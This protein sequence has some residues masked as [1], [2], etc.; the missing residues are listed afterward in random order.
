[1]KK[2]LKEICSAYNITEVG[3]CPM[4]PYENLGTR[5]KNRAEFNTGF[6]EEDLDKRINPHLLMPKGQ[7]II[8]CLFPYYTGKQSGNLS[9][10]TY[11]KDYHLLCKELLNQVGEDLKK[12]IPDLEYMSFADT[13]PL[14]DRYLAHEAGLGFYG[15][16]SHLINDTFGSYFFIGYMITNYPFERDY[17]LDK[18]CFGCLACKRKCP[19]QIILGNYDIDGRGCRSFITQKKGELDPQDLKVLRRGDKI[20]GCDVCQQVCPHN[21][22][23]PE[24]PF[25]AFKENLITELSLDDLE[26]LSNKGFKRTYG[27][28][29]FSWRGKKILIRNI[30]LLKEGEEND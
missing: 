27:D 13:G 14:V 11:G 10:Y 2:R 22:D 18:T 30:Q 24:T 15:I 19:G 26:S 7:S 20:F 29:A 23:L 4:G 25:K 9:N 8:V 28:R 17:P 12:E 3:I 21:K 5:L 16:N 1:M 6:E